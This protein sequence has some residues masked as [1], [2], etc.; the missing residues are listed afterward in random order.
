MRPY[1]IEL[2][3]RALEAEQHY[4]NE[5][6]LLALIEKIKSQLGIQ[7]DLPPHAFI[8]TLIKDHSHLTSRL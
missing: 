5:E 2:M 6:P 3:Q 4:G 7:S 8:H 1:D